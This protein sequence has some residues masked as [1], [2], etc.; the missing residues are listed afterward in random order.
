MQKNE[1][2]KTVFRHIKLTEESNIG[3]KERFKK[4][5][6]K[7]YLRQLLTPEEETLI[8]ETN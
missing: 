4:Q 1:F 5:L 3:R 6:R 2:Q 8:Q 7:N